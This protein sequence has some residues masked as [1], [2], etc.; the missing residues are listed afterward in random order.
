MFS[1]QI[2]KYGL[3]NVGLIFI[4]II[5]IVISVIM[6]NWYNL[7]CDIRFR[8][9]LRRGASGLLSSRNCTIHDLAMSKNS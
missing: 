7:I 1:I 5:V 4:V 8:G 9:G 3:C 2:S 6:V